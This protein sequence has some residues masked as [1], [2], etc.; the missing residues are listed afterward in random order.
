MSY[1]E[2]NRRLRIDRR[3][4]FAGLALLFVSAPAS[5]AG[6][7][8]K[9][10]EADG[11]KVFRKEVPGSPLVAFRGE[12]MISAPLEKLLWVLADNAHR[13]EWVDRLKKSVVLQTN[14]SYE[15]IVYQH[16]GLPFPISDRDYV[17][18]GK[19]TRD[20]NGVVTLDISSVTHPKAP[21]TVGVRANV[22]G[23]R[24]VLTPKGPDKTYVVVEIHTDPKGAIPTWLVN[25][26]QKSWPMKT[27]QNMRTQ[28]AKPFV[29]R[30]ELPPDE[31]PKS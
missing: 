28:V 3:T 20:K 21:A 10:D 2:G 4:L 24:Y 23:S 26:I 17:Y 18:R 8:E 9:I 15:Y 12:G 22:I 16:F 5:A 13:T 11:I 31:A 7:W 19:A 29:K 30:L 27:L 1:D 6:V 25:L 14:G